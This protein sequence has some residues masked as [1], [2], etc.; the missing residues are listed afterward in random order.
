MNKQVK[1]LECSKSC[2]ELAQILITIAGMLIIASGY[3][4]VSYK[5]D[6]NAHLTYGH[7]CETIA[8]LNNNTNILTSCVDKISGAFYPTAQKEKFYFY[9]LFI[10]AILLSFASIFSWAY[11]KRGIKK[12]DLK[13]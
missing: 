5:S 6:S 8:E 4:W 13:N 11:G 12:I 7:I 9:V 2:F 10:F 3:F 1:S